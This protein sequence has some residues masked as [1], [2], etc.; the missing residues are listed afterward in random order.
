MKF[1]TLHPETRLIVVLSI[2]VCV[3]LLALLTEGV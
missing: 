1:Q 2:A 3:I